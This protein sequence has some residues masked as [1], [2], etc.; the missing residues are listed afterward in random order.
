M[1]AE[2]TV[3]EVRPNVTVIESFETPEP[4][5]A[6]EVPEEPKAEQEE[7][8]APEEEQERGEDGK[9]KP[10][11]SIQDRFD[12]LTRQKHEAAR[13]AAYWRGLAEQRA[14]KETAPAERPTGKPS[15]DQFEDHS[16]YVEAL[17][18][19]KV[20]QKLAE[21]EQRQQEQAKASTWAE[22]AQAVKAEL[23]DFDSVMATSTAPMSAAMAEAIKDS[24]I[25]PKVAY[26][27]AQHPEE[28]ARLSSMSP[29]AA[30][31]EIGKIEATLLTP[32]AEPQK[33]VTSAPTPPTPIGSGRSTVGDPAKMSMSDYMAWRD[34]QRKQ[35]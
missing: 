4:P 13:E 9:F 23:P 6:E 29:M 28:A 22:R 20:E 3:A 14:A 17:A 1:S 21:R 5:K 25:G 15:A 11:K 27:L 10:K 8:E 32:K 18:D 26:H 35:K 31:R 16:E 12:D 30:A 33:K 2:E 24:D 34:A 19:W 7:V